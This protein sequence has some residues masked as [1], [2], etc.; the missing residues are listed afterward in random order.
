MIMLLITALW[1]ARAQQ[2]APN[3]TV[4]IRM[5]PRWKWLERMTIGETI[6]FAALA[7]S[8][9]D[10]PQAM[11]REIQDPFS[12]GKEMAAFIGSLDQTPTIATYPSARSQAVLPWLPNRNLKFWHV[13]TG[14]FGTFC[15]ET[16][17]LEGFKSQTQEDLVAAVRRGF[18]LV[19]PWLLLAVPLPRPDLCGYELAHQSP[20]RAW[21]FGAEDFWLYKPSTASW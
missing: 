10:V 19:K 7:I 15:K 16:A 3:I 6:V 11:L 1:V 18:P 14:S 17:A 8:V 2:H 4:R 21:G 13:E 20:Q 5:G 12:G 9:V